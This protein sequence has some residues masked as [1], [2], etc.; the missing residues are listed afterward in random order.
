MV[1]PVHQSRK[2]P[3]R[4]PDRISFFLLDLSDTLLLEP[5]EVGPRKTRVKNDICEHC[6]RWIEV[7][8]QRFERDAG[9]IQLG[10]GAQIGSQLGQLITDLKRRAAGGTLVQHRHGKAGRPGNS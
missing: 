9:D 1:R 6:H 8:F 5:L 10:A 7:L 3:Q 2:D 4:Q